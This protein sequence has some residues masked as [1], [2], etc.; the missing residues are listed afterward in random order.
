MLLQEP[1]TIEPE[2]QDYFQSAVLVTDVK[3]A[4]ADTVIAHL[5]QQ[6]CLRFC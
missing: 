5:P 1:L 3:S 6:P 4:V 2:L